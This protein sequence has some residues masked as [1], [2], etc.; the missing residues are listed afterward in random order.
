MKKNN[1]ET[2]L[3][4]IDYASSKHMKVNQIKTTNVNI[5]LNRVRMD[6]KRDIKRKIFFSMFLITVLSSLIIY[7][8]D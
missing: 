4:K 2:M 6:K 8:L 3:E 5:L 7:F 1:H